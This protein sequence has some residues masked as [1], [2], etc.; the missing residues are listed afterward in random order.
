MRNPL[1]TDTGVYV[2]S[3]LFAVLVFVVAVAVLVLFTPAEPSTGELLTF[4]V[5]FL[6]FVGVYFV[7]MVVYR[8]LDR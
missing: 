8:R 4:T 3:G 1:D 5:G 2:V 6:L 7:A